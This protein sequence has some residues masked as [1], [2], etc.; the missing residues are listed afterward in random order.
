MDKYSV[1]ILGSG[2]SGT[3]AALKIAKD[4]K[5]IK[6]ILID[7]GAKPAKRKS[8]MMG[9]LG[10]LPSSDGKLFL[11]DISSLAQ[12]TGTKKANTAYKWFNSYIKNIIDAKIIKDRSPNISMEKKIRKAG[13]DIQ[14]NNHIQIY[15]KDIHTLSKHIANILYS[16][17][18]IT[19]SFDNEVFDIKKNKRSFIIE[20]QNGEI[21]AKRIVIAVGRSGWRQAKQWYD[22]FDIV[23]NNDI[24]KFGVRIEATSSV[25]KDFNKSCCSLVNNNLRIGPLSNGGTVLPEDHIDFANSSYRSNEGR[26]ASDKVSFEFI[27]DCNFPGRGIEETDRL[28]QL[29]FVLCND[30]LVKEKLSSIIA[31]KSIISVL[32]EFDFL[33][34]E[35][36][37]I[38]EW[39]PDLIAKGYFYIPCVYPIF[40]TIKV[41]NNFSTDANGVYVA[42]ESSGLHGLLAAALSG[43]SVGDSVCK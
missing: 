35:L 9:F 41:N 33:I 3:F 25:M 31:K 32:P 12:I 7:T 20:T 8:Q 14:L 18:N 23:E 17:K 19:M 1:A 6:T 39:F 28:A 2:L 40:S 37:N 22:E 27:A 34:H 13:F 10:L 29:M 5:N 30:R 11:N 43:I 42:G 4:H 38:I 36:K 16:S 26:W 24:A 21:E 15:P